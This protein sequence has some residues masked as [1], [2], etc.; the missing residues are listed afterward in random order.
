MINIIRF[1]LDE[2]GVIT[3]Y[4]HDKEDADNPTTVLIGGWAVDSYNP[5]FG[6]IDIDLITNS[7]T[8]TSLSFHLRKDHDFVPYR[9]AGIPSSIKKDTESG[10]VI[11]DFASR[12]NPFPFEGRGELLDFSILD[13]N[14]E[15]RLIRESIEMPVPNRATLLILK[16]KAIWDRQYRIEQQASD[17]IEW[18]K[19]KLIKDYADVLALI[20]PNYGGNQIEISVLGKL[21]AMYS[22]LEKSLISVYDSDDG[23]A[24]YGRMSQD[25]AKLTIDQIISL[26]H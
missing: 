1:S 9:L 11:I 19:G 6:S 23:V 4:L 26:S 21:L 17:N 14:T 7:S 24:K 20:D 5:W 10:A 12:Q 8:R 3:K 15:T 18:E 22:F 2:L 16:L 13:G 25:D